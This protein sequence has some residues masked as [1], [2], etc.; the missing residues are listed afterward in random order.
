[1]QITHRGATLRYDVNALTFSIEANDVSWQTSK[2]PYMVTTAG[3]EISFLNAGKITHEAWKTGLGDGFLS[4]FE[5][6]PGVNVSFETILWLDNCR[7]E[8]FC[9]LLPYDD[10]K[11]ALKEVCFP[12]AFDF[13]ERRKDWYTVLPMGQGL[14]LPNDHDG[15]FNTYGV[16]L[17]YSLDALMPFYGQVRDGRFYIAITQTPWDAGYMIDIKKGGPYAVWQRW[18]PSLGRMDYR[19]VMRF[20]FCRGDYN[21]MAKVYRQYADETGNLITLAEK[22]VRNPIVNKLMGSAIVHFQIFRNIAATSRFYDSQNPENNRKVHATFDQ[23][24]DIMRKL[25]AL[26]VEKVYFHMDGWGHAGY[27]NQ[28][29][30][31]TP[32]CEEAGGWEGMKRLSDTMKELNYIFATHDQYRDYFFDAATFDEEMA[33]R[34]LDGSITIHGMWAGGKQTYLCATQAPGYVRRNNIELKEHG[35]ELEGTY[36]DVF[37]I[38]ELEE[39]DHPRHRMTRKECLEYRMRC[40][41]WCTAN[42]IIISSEDG[43][44]WS[45][46]SLVLCHH[47]PY[48][49][50]GDDFIRGEHLGVPVPLFNLV[51]HDCLLQPMNLKKGS[52]YTG[53]LLDDE[54][55]F[56]YALLLAAPGYLMM[57]SEPE[58][59]TPERVTQSRIV[60]KLQEYIGMAEMLRHEYLP[61]GDQRTTWPGGITVTINM[62][63]DTW[64]VEGCGSDL[65]APDGR[66]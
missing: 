7:G 45:I 15:P 62:K 20:S 34:N 46:K 24:A 4:R 53:R 23:A 2:A 13:S 40:F 47:S 38:I 66:D 37:T 49:A 64:K 21:D 3:E 41:D 55:G 18:A 31:C 63:K 8:L 32:P 6:F 36:Q 57:D 11:C 52:D 19:R 28:H 35:I 29:P 61:N 16:G 27:D 22:A 60:S 33:V 5:D 43:I 54:N 14:I 26:G 9:E 50:S 65:F 56:L 17:Y 1:M 59:P 51:Y 58:N 42:G 44:D 10:P 30:D 39:C 25:K 48:A 12:T